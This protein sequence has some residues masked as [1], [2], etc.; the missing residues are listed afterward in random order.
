MPDSRWSHTLNDESWSESMDGQDDHN[1][2]DQDGGA[3]SQSELRNG[4]RGALECLQLAP[5]QGPDKMA[6]GA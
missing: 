4:E 2:H 1:H 6:D 5:V 3:V